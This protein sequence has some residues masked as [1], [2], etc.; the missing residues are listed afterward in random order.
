[1]NNSIKNNSILNAINLNKKNYKT[2]S[3]SNNL[4]QDLNNDFL[5][6]LLKKI[7]HKNLNQNISK[8]KCISNLN[9][10]RNIKKLYDEDEEDNSVEML[11]EYHNT[12]AYSSL[13]NKRV[14]IE[15]SEVV[16]TN[17]IIIGARFPKDIQNV[18]V[19][20]A[21]DNR[22]IIFSKDLGPSPAGN[23]IYTID[24]NEIDSKYYNT[25]VDHPSIYNFAI[26]AKNPLEIVPAVRL[27]SDIV[28]SI[29]ASKNDLCL[30]LN[31]LGLC[32]FTGLVK[33]L[34]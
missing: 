25:D 11:K 5:K 24:R 29:V 21:D 33:I 14:L 4:N 28:K 3:K 18:R 31:S 10:S 34:S 19:V 16:F 8:N 9:F 6:I 27:S 20:F 30:N 1:M 15:T 26:V 12:T 23:N 17:P 7:D 13:V 2:N 32:S 22:N